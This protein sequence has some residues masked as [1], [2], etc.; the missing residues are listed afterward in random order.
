MV[1][2]SYYK[3]KVYVP[4]EV[5]EKLGLADGDI[6]RIEV[7]GRDMVK[8]TVVRGGDV[9]ERILKRLND[10]PDIGRLKGKLRREELYEDIT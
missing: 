5:Q 9:A 1:E 3:D 2:T 7:I 8:L 10:P 6:L 4:R